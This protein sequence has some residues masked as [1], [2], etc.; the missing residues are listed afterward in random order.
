MSVVVLPPRRPRT[1]KESD[2][3][4]KIREELGKIPHVIVW[5]NNTG[6]LEDR[7][8]TKVRFG[9]CE[10]SADL[11]GM[12]TMRLAGE[13]GCPAGLV[14]GRFIAIEVKQ[15]GKK[16]TAVQLKFIDIVRSFGGAACWVDNVA[17]ALAF[18]E[19]VRMGVE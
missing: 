17:D 14:V 8:G 19:R 10:G 11:V 6:M 16:P 15:P 18:V 13:V 1:V 2:I 5:R 12:V 9:L 7:N 3:L 4:R